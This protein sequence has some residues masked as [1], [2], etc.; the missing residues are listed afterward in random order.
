MPTKLGD[1]DV[2][3]AVAIQI[4]CL[5][6]CNASDV[7]QERFCP[8]K[9]QR[10]VQGSTWIPSR[11]VG[12]P[13]KLAELMIC[14]QETTQVRYQKF[15]N[16]IAVQITDSDRNRVRGGMRK[17]LPMMLFGIAEI[18][19]QVGPWRR[20]L[21]PLR[22]LRRVRFQFSSQRQRSIRCCVR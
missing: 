15:R 17:I 11:H 8:G 12:D 1:H 19:F 3:V 2:E 20:P 21:R 4:A 9:L 14:G 6:I 18:S 22:R 10:M 7:P 16:L 5:Y 13:E